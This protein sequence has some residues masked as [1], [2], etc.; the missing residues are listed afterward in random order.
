MAS[1]ERLPSGRWRAR[2]R[3]PSGKRLSHTDPLK[4]VVV[5]WAQE[6][7]AAFRAGASAESSRKL[8]VGE[9]CTRWL[10]TRAVEPTTA[11]KNASH[12]RMHLLPRWG[13]WPLASVARSDV[14][15]WVNDMGRAGVGAPTISATYNL[16]SSMLSDAVLEGILPGSPCREIDLPRVV[17]PAARWLTRLEYDRIQLALAVTPRAPVYQAYVALACFSGLRPGELAGLDVEHVDFERSLVRVQQV[18]TRHGLRAYPK[19]DHSARWVPFPSE[20]GDLLWRL[21]GDR[22]QGPVFTSPTGERVNEANFRNRIWRPALEAAGVEPVRVYCMRHTAASWLAQDGVPE[23]D[24]ARILGH[25]STRIV[26]TYAHHSPTAFERVRA[27]WAQAGAEPLAE[28]N[29]A[30]RIR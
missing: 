16:F 19:T 5:V 30:T 24:I 28:S 3:H 18:M 20:V 9:W 12:L 8:T 22:A 13:S 26:S 10:R 21:L 4:R 14:Q 15:A 17:K 2:V 6:Q 29:T 27:T 23:G 11:A 1:V 25:S 7:E